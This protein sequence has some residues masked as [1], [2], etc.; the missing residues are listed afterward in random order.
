MGGKVGILA[1]GK[2]MLGWQRWLLRGMAHYDYMD[3]RERLYMAAFNREGQL[4]DCMRF[5]QSSEQA[6]N[7]GMAGERTA[8]DHCHMKGRSQWR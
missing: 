7:L 5:A 3:E 4:N 6:W 2:S 8:H 1:G